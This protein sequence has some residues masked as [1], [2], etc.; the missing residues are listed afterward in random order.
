MD[1]TRPTREGSENNG[2]SAIKAKDKSAKIIQ[3]NKLMY[4]GKLYDSDSL[5]TS[6]LPLHKVHQKETPTGIFFKGHLSPLSNFSPTTIIIDNI[7]FNSVEQYYQA[8]RARRHSDQQT[9]MKIMDEYD[10]AEMKGF[11]KHL[12]M[13][14]K[15]TAEM[16]EKEN[17]KVMMTALRKKFEEPN[18]KEFLIGTGE[19]ILAE[20]SYDVVWGTGIDLYKSNCGSNDFT[21][22]NR[23]G[24]MLMELRKEFTE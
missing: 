5:R 14:P 1:E 15:I 9:F 13:D 10:P 20:A 19:K 3:G 2:K 23:L 8:E 21:G 22:L 17:Q 7:R 6:G 16:E 12:S 11:A 24:K 4:N 18:M